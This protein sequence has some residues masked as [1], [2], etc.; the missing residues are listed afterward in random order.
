MK[1]LEVEITYEYLLVVT[2]TQNALQLSI[3]SHLSAENF[4][5]SVYEV[6]MLI[7]YSFMIYYVPKRTISVI[8]DISVNVMLCIVS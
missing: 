5:I 1:S 6:D 3:L 2:K 8:D 7:N 4:L